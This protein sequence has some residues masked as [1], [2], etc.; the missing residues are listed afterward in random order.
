VNIAQKANN[1]GGINESRFHSD[2]YDA[3]YDQVAVATDAEAA[4]ALFIQMNDF[5][6][7]NQVIIPE[8]ARAAE[9]YAILNT[10]NDA[11]VGGSLF[12]ALYWNIANWN[13]VQ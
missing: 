12:E 8:V 7:T 2:E 1:W 13:R 11:N 10:L 5:L 9:K 4:A 3:M 6:I